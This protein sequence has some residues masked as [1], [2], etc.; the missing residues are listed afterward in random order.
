MFEISLKVCGNE[1]HH[2]QPL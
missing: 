1:F 2:E